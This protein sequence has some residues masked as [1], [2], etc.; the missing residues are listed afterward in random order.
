MLKIIDIIN[1]EVVTN[2][3]EVYKESMDDLRS[4]F[5][6]ICEMYKM[7]EEFLKDFIKKHNQIIL[8]EC[9]EGEWVSSLRAIE[10][11]KGYWFLEGVETNPKKRKKGFGSALLL[12]SIEYLKELGMIEITCIISKNNINSQKLHEKCGFIQTS[13]LPINCW[14]ELEEKSIL[15][16]INLEK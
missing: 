8:V 14:N 12:H 13:D 10:T 4:N 6:S 5:N 11:K 2:L 9:F 16:K 15:Y 3:F 7:Y 1:K